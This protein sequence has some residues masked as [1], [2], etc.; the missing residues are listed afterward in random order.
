[1]DTI[2]AI[3]NLTKVC[4]NGYQALKDISLD[5]KE[6][7]ILALLGPNGVE[8]TTLISTI[9]GLVLPT[10]GSITVNGFDIE[11]DYRQARAL[12]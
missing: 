12:I 7:E 6:G 1:M 11:K 3:E 2:I 8:K 5:I 4:D 10:S 9:C